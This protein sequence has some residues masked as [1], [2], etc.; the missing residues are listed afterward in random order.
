[1]AIDNLRK[2]Y[3]SEIQEQRSAE[4]QLVQALPQMAEL[5]S[6]AGLAEAL[7]G[8]LRETRTQ[9]DRLDQ[10]LSAHGAEP[11]AHEDS[12]MTRI[13][14]ESAKWA[15]MIDD[16]Q[17]RDAGIIASAQRVEHYEIAVYGTLA[18]WAKQLGLENDME[19]LL[20]ILDEEKAA[21]E[22]LTGIAKSEANPQAVH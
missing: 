8:H 3:L 9:L 20:E 21:D 4:E 15:N 11:R 19:T 12:S 22:K 7:Q 5:A 16:P 10:L 18:T 2:M 1:M 6:D 17:A 14:E 13:I